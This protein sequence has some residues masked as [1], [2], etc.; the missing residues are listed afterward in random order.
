M[1]ELFD[2]HLDRARSRSLLFAVLITAL[3]GL[4]SAGLVAAQEDAGTVAEASDHSD[5]WSSVVD[6]F[7]VVVLSRSLLLEPLDGDI[8]LQ[9]IE[10]S[11]EGVALDGED[12]DYDE[13]ADR[14]G[15]ED[16]DLLFQLVALDHVTRMSMFDEGPAEAAEAEVPVS[17]M[18]AI[19]T[20][21][22][23]IED[24]MDGD[25][26]RHSKDAKVIVGQAH[27]VEADEVTRDMVVFGGPL[28]IHGK[29]IGDAVAF[30]GPITVSGEVTGDVV[31]LGGSTTLTETA[32]VLGEVVSVG[33]RVDR[34]EGAEVIGEVVEVD[35]LPNLRFDSPNFIFR[36]RPD[37]D[38]HDLEELT[39]V[40]VAVTFMW[41]GF[42]LVVVALLAAL[43]ML[44][45]RQPLQRVGR[46]AAQEPW[47]SGAVGLVSQIMVLPLLIM[48]VLILCISIIGIPLLLLVPFACLA[49]VLIAFMGF[50]AVCWNIGR[51]LCTRFG[52]TLPSPYFELF[53]G[54]VAVQIWTVL[55]HLLD[56]GWG[57]LWFFGAMLCVIG[58]MIKYA[59]WTIG[60]G[61]AVL[62]RFGSAEG[63]RR[64]GPASPVTTSSVSPT[65]GSSPVIDAGPAAG[66]ELD[67]LREDGDEPPRTDGEL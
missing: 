39:P 19:E 26:S 8:E 56:V 57:P 16:A 64:E 33:G 51:F 36:G 49:L 12:L 21:Q 15:A 13:V 32:Q 7:E 65:Q 54:V 23:R 40:H 58:V 41:A 28:T 31:S 9:R 4:L 3:I 20:A 48:V 25:G 53:L 34:A 63:W 62:T 27:V 43:V 14:L 60:L 50:C 5:L 52:W 2:A 18:E 10:I 61:A 29:V 1:L 46:R 55:G 35:F 45:A 67:R 42:R 6:R 17:A 24:E 30:G 11:D 66:N 38:R 59:T 22:Q 37:R 44:L 47:K